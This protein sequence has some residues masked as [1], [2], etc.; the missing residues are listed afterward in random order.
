MCI[1]HMFKHTSVMTIL[2]SCFK[3][4]YSYQGDWHEMCIQHLTINY[5]QQKF[6]KIIIDN[7]IVQINSNCNGQCTF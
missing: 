7:K 4:R 2:Y 1:S 3:C 5:L 6:K